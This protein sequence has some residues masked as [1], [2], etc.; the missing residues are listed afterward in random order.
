[1]RKEG[2]SNPRYGNPYVS[3]ANWWF[4]P[5]THPSLG[6]YGD[7][8]ERCIFQMRCKDKLRFFILQINPSILFRKLYVALSSDSF[9]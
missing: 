1:M 9:A 7:I 4:Q 5:L 3:L 8:P 6:V 2:D